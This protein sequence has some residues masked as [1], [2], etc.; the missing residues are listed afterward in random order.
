M[1]LLRSPPDTV[2]V[3]PD[4]L[5]GRRRESNLGF[6]ITTRMGE[7]RALDHIVL[8]VEVA[9]IHVHARFAVP[10]EEAG[11]I[12][13]VAQDEPAVEEEVE[14]VGDGSGS[15]WDVLNSGSGRHRR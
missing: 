1:A 6:P 5:P 11:C 2:R 13:A 8:D 14:A 4:R 9:A 12:A 7:R 15:A 10:D 3:E